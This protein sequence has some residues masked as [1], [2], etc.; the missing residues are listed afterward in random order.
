MIIEHWVGQRQGDETRKRRWHEEE[1][2]VNV[3]ECY[4]KPV[5]RLYNDI[6]ATLFVFLYQNIE[7][8]TPDTP[9]APMKPCA[10]T[11]GR[12]G[13]SERGSLFDEC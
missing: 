4:E 9:D 1:T 3:P 10:S 11:S 12:L 2:M 5:C 8:Y 6:I 7:R 13:G